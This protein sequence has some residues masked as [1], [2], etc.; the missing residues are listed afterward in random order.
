M[1]DAYPPDLVNG[2]IPVVFAVNAVDSKYVTPPWSSTSTTTHGSSL[3]PEW[4]NDDVVGE[5]VPQEGTDKTGGS[6]GTS[7]PSWNGPFNL[8]IDAMSLMCNKD[9]YKH[10]HRWSSGSDNAG[11]VGAD[12]A[13]SDLFQSDGQQYHDHH[14]EL[15]SREILSGEESCTDEEDD[16]H[17]N[18][19]KNDDNDETRR[20]RRGFASEMRKRIN[21][22][23]RST[24]K[25]S[26]TAKDHPQM[27]LHQQQRAVMEDGGLQQ[28]TSTPTMPAFF[29]RV[30]IIPV[31][32]RHAF[33]PSKDPNGVNNT[34]SPPGMSSTTNAHHYHQQQQNQNQ[35]Y[36]YNYNAITHDTNASVSAA[37]AA[38]KYQQ[39]PVEQFLL[40]KIS[41]NPFS[42]RRKQLHIDRATTALEPTSK[43]APPSSSTFSTHGD[44]MTI[45]P[46]TD[47]MK[48]TS[49]E[50][51]SHHSKCNN[52][53]GIIPV[54]WLEKH[55][56]WLPSVVL[57]VMALDLNLPQSLRVE[58][59]V[60]LGETIDNIRSSLAPKRECRIHLV[61]LVTNHEQLKTIQ[62]KHLATSQQLTFVRSQCRLS[63]S[64]ITMLYF[65]G[66]LVV[67]EQQSN[68]QLL[69]TIPK[70]LPLFQS[71]SSSTTTTTTANAAATTATTHINELSLTSLPLKQLYRTARD[72]SLSYYL[73][74]ARR[75][76][77]KISS[78]HSYDNNS[79]MN[80]NL[81][82]FMIRYQFKISIYYEFQLKLDRSV[83]HLSEAYNAAELYYKY[84]TNRQRQVLSVLQEQIYYYTQQQLRKQNI[85]DQVLED[86][87]CGNS[88]VLYNNNGG[89]NHVYPAS[90]ADLSTPVTPQRK[91]A[92]S[93]IQSPNTNADDAVEVA[94]IMG[95]P[96]PNVG[97][98]ATSNADSDHEDL[99]L[100]KQQFK[101]LPVS[102]M[103]FQCRGVADWINFKLMKYTFKYSSSNT[104]QQQIAPGV[105]KSSTTDIKGVGGGAGIVHATMQWR[106]HSQVFL[107]TKYYHTYDNIPKISNCPLLLQPKWW[108]SSYVEHQRLA[109]A[110]LA[111]RYPLQL[112]NV[113]ST[114]ASRESLLISAGWRLY[115][116]AAEATL[117]TCK[118]V[119]CEN[120]S[121]NVTHQCD[122]IDEDTAQEQHYSASQYVGGI[123]PDMLENQFRKETRK[124]HYH[125][126]LRY[127]E[128]AISLFYNLDGHNRISWYDCTLDHHE[129]RLAAPLH[130]L[131]GNLSMNKVIEEYG[132]SNDYNTISAGL[133]T[134]MKHLH[135]ALG[136]VMGWPTLEAAIAK[137]LIRCYS[138]L[139][140][141]GIVWDHAVLVNA[142]T[143]LLFPDIFQCRERKPTIG[144]EHI[145]QR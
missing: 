53:V 108:H 17:T 144:R 120:H 10:V 43:V 65:P 75:L 94:L 121:K 70:K 82:P 30:R 52:N 41:P 68:P 15:Y 116:A 111:E 33:P 6:I 25:P 97:A 7:A 81:L 37:T 59:D 79:T 58:R 123:D 42:L 64:N 131:F 139:T 113:D 98:A 39:Q 36:Q 143:F 13:P 69:T 23:N 44:S 142:L 45:Y 115:L 118:Q 104:T 145:R 105:D 27:S 126:A 21:Y 83:K 91:L 99:L 12:S 84:I 109:I 26:T 55:C 18:L 114:S 28:T 88:E 2:A 72:L 117:Q 60:Q 100:M 61:C 71:Q 24:A 125:S 40:D 102:D 107:S 38:S 3:H 34:I 119:E 50:G 76:K 112:Q 133:E 73:T 14:N 74:A 106:R 1:Q 77:R 134:A 127:L 20:I 19:G 136:L 47:T 103:A 5:A 66:D 101:L 49:S 137:T 86:E 80:Y 4:Q 9:S 63:P 48:T 96:P 130:Y 140:E 90:Y 124:Q 78:L 141:L 22:I 93:K 54:D 128:R 135:H 92:K 129:G 67:G 87:E 85:L 95:S 35:R 132:D 46:P 51:G 57:V 32:K 16:G 8:F 56:Q 11:R 31:S 110:E 122:Q 89:G 62:Q 29:D 138:K